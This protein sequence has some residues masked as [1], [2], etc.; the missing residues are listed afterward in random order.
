MKTIP[1][2]YIDGE[3]VESTAARSWTSSI[4]LTAKG[5]HKRHWQ[6]RRTRGAASPPL[7][8]RSQLTARRRLDERPLS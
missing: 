7:S 4:R 5:S 2:H 3:L 8:G 6:M 1:T